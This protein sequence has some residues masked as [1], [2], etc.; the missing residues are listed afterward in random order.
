MH[1]LI[2]DFHAQFIT[3]DLINPP[4]YPWLFYPKYGSNI[5]FEKSRIL[6]RLYRITSHKATIVTAQTSHVSHTTYTR[7]FIRLLV[8]YD[9]V[10]NSLYVALVI[11]T[12]KACVN[13]G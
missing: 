13:K 4:N 6:N 2:N 10:R 11:M 3:S 1:I 7:L 12:M 8:V 9:A 5:F